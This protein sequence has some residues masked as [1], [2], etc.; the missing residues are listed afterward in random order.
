MDNKD[1]VKEAKVILA[2]ETIAKYIK[3]HYDAFV[4]VGFSPT[5]ALE[6]VKSALNAIIR[7]QQKVVNSKG[8]SHGTGNI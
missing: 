4:S 1:P 2:H 8:K 3:N 5:Q 7:E 6:L